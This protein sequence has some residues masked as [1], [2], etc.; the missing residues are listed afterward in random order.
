MTESAQ[1]NTKFTAKAMLDGKELL[2]HKLKAGKYYEAQKIYIGMADRIRAAMQKSMTPE[3]LKNEKNMDGTDEKEM[4]ALAGKMKVA[5]LYEIVPTEVLKL[6][7]FCIDKPEKE[8]SEQ[9]YPEE[10]SDIADK[11]IELN[12]FKDNLKKSVAPMGN[13]GQDV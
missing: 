8:L 2:I 11:V 4:R 3:E 12:N 1:I 9:A 5:T 6:V 10:I 7:A 13:L